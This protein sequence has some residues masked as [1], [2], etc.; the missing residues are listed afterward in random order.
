VKAQLQRQI[1]ATD[2]QIDRLV[3]GLV[4]LT[5]EEVGVVA[6]EA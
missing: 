2:G 4:G 3:Y 1:D 6:G 5:A